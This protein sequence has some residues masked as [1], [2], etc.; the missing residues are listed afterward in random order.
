MKFENKEEAVKSNLQDCLNI[1]D[2]HENFKSRKLVIFKNS[3]PFYI[4]NTDIQSFSF[5]QN[6]KVNCAR[7]LE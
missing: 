2:S 3:H 6:P 5:G 1:M 7:D 4:K